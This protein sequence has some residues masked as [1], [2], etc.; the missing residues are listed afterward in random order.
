MA[1]ELPVPRL[2][3]DHVTGIETRAGVPS[4][5]VPAGAVGSTGFTVMAELVAD[6][7]LEPVATARR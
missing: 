6:L 5:N 1:D 4:E 3:I 2:V 7:P